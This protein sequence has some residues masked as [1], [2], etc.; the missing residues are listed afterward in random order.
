MKTRLFP[1]AFGVTGLLALLGCVVA[2]H[3][4]ARNVNALNAIAPVIAFLSEQGQRFSTAGHPWFDYA[5]VAAVALLA[6]VTARTRV[7][8]H[9]LFVC[10]L[11][12]AIVA[13]LFL[14]DRELCAAIVRSLTGSPANPA[15]PTPQNDWLVAVPVGTAGYLTALALFYVGWKRE[16]EPRLFEMGIEESQHFGPADLLLLTGIVL[17][18]I[19][20][21]MY[22]L[23]VISDG[24]E[25]E[26][27]P[28]SA[29]ATS[30][31]GL[32][33]ANR[34]AYGPWAPLGILYYLPI[35]VTTNLFGTTLLAL[36]L[37]SAIVG[38]LTVPLVYLLAARLGGRMAGH[39]AAAL[40]ALNCL[41]IGWSRTDIHPHGVT[42]WPTLLLCWFLLKAFDTR[43][44]SWAC[45]VAF[46]MGLSW[47][48]YPSGQSA[49]SIPLIAIALYWIGNR[50]ALPL[51]WSHCA[52]VGC[53]VLLWVF[54]LPLSYYLADG[55]WFFGNPFNLTGPRALWGGNQGPVSTLGTMQFVLRMAI[56]HLG[57]VI[58][59]VFYHQPY[60][61]HQEWVPYAPMFFS[62][63]VPWLEMPFVVLG[64][65]IV[66]RYRRRFESAVLL[67]W[68]V[69]AIVP[70]I[71]S[72]HAYA[73]R[74]STFFPALDILAALALTTLVQCS[75]ARPRPWPRRLAVSAV[76]LG[77]AAYSAFLAHVWFSGR[78]WKYGEPV[79]IQIAAQISKSITPGT[80]VVA[81]L[82][83]GSDAGKYL[84]LLVDYL[85]D[86]R[87]R[88]NLWMAARTPTLPRL[89]QDPML[90]VR[91]FAETW[92]Y[93]WTKL[94]DQVDETANYKQWTRVLFL[95]QTGTPDN[96]PNDELIAAAS[97]RCRTPTIRK[98]QGS[99]AARNS[100]V[101]IECAL[102]DLK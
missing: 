14:V 57:D 91:L 87:N 85:S 31:K 19:A 78:F 11:A 3:D 45:G 42:T 94:R 9:R 51:R 20:F 89:V 71:L 56:E 23:N 55:R 17:V 21:R 99:R 92:P 63:T 79:E 46:M 74:L 2:V 75:T 24:F 53:G 36:R 48:Q 26:L 25:G 22:A 34:G 27:S 16:R 86:P 12:T 4:S 81:D 95:L 43:K 54:G 72:E 84:Y 5:A 98:I 76:A 37:S 58:Q 96:Y 28:Y 93:V 77:L 29:A 49:V 18:A 50:G 82:N 35:S 59:G 38:V 13:Q 10:A 33:L 47:H 88:P 41:H 102:A 73:K 66:V 62:R 44:L 65:A 15:A 97:A 32:L 1:V 101:L 64:A 6:L 80:I 70:G 52:L 90:S 68:L 83:R 30:L 69:A 40:F 8:S 100:L 7:A 61:F 60:F 39:L 67:A